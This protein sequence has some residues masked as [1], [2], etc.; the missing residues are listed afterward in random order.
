YGQ[1]ERTIRR[2]LAE[3]GASVPKRTTDVADATPTE[4][5]TPE[6]YLGYVRL[7]PSRYRGRTLRRNVARAYAFPHVLPRNA[8]S[9]SGVWKIGDQRAL[10]VAGARLRL[11]FHA[12]NVYVVLGGHGVVWSFVDGKAAGSVRID[13]DRLYTLVSRQRRQDAL[14]ELRFPTGV[15]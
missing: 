13:A 7:D 15:N 5:I 11:H 12:R 4:I 6:S 2:L 3:N 9:Y 1:S 10:A 14:L 8:L